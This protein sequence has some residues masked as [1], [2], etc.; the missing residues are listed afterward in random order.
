MD[1]LIVIRRVSRLLFVVT[2]DAID[3]RIQ[4]PP[5]LAGAFE[6]PRQ[7]DQC[8]ILV[9]L[10]RPVKV[11][12]TKNR[13]DRLLPPVDIGGET[14]RAI[15]VSLPPLQEANEAVEAHVGSR[16]AL[17][18]RIRRLAQESRIRLAETN[19]GS[20]YRHRTS[21]SPR[22]SDVQRRKRLD[23]PDQGLAQIR[24][25]AAAHGP[26][27]GAVITR[28]RPFRRLLR[29]GDGLH[30]PRV[31]RRSIGAF[32]SSGSGN[33]VGIGGGT[34]GVSNVTTPPGV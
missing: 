6:V 5:P 19:Y 21:P 28:C 1:L 2:Q 27:E 15:V 12:S 32:P 7:H 22:N 13:H 26:L 9:S 10:N 34:T 24:A 8:A 20:W 25:H 17:A 23:D 4:Q 31:V 29:R 33:N 3:V 16:R 14:D 11:R 30:Q 18:E